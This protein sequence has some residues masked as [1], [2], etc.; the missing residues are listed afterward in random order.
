MNLED[1]KAFLEVVV[2]FAELKGKQLSAPALELYWNAMRG[3]WCL[4][5]FRAAAAHLLQTCEFMPTP[6]DFEDLRRKGEPTAGEAWQLA[7]HGK[8][9]PGSRA[10]R[11]AAIVSNGRRLAMMDIEREL[12]HVQRRFF[13]VY[14]DLEDAD[15]ARGGV[16]QIA[17][18][19]AAEGLTHV[20]RLQRQLPPRMAE[21][22]SEP[23]N[24]RPPSRQYASDAGNREPELEPET[25]DE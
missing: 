16:P 11:A 22:T 10:A 17:G 19:R 9:E 18:Q 12:P 15:E 5:D 4:D 1:R 23:R 21:T 3:R 25:A 24:D 8:A 7:L 14:A 6:K 2:G 20:G 13:E